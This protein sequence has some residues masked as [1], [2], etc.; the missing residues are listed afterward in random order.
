[1]QQFYACE[2]SHQINE[3]QFTTAQR[4]ETWILLEYPRP[5]TAK[6]YEDSTI[7]TK[8]KAYIDAQMA[9]MAFPRLQ[10][11]A[12]SHNE[13]ELTDLSLYVVRNGFQHNEVRHFK[14][15]TYEALLDLPLADIAHGRSELGEI[16]EEPVYIVCTNGKRDVCCSRYG[17]P[18]YNALHQRDRGHVWQS[19]HIGGHRFAGTL[20]TFPH[21]IYYGRITPEDVSALIDATEAGDVLLSYIRGRSSAE[22]MV[23]AAEYYLRRETGNLALDAFAVT[24]VRQDGEA[25]WQ[26]SFEDASD[27]YEI[28][29]GKDMSSFEIFTDSTSSES[30]AVPQFALIGFE[31][32]GQ[33]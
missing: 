25:R 9:L 27:R 20:V 15:A 23:Q 14:L 5:W 32:V 4:A 24:D 19:N 1:M 8:V 31:V 30:K 29:V 13:N 18:V 3:A 16:V 28:A 26:V 33:G 6:A 17:L 22:P 2:H 21:G 11:I 10:M 12:H 7:P